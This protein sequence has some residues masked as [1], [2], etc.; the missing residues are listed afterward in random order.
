MRVEVPTYVA[1][2]IDFASGA[3]GTIVMSFDVWAAELPRIEVYGTEGSL[4]VPNPNGSG[5][6]VKVRRSGANPPQRGRGSRYRRGGHGV[7]ASLRTA[8]PG[9]R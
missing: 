1:G 9:D 4:S 8:A 2:V 5:G 3:I 7:R 6:P